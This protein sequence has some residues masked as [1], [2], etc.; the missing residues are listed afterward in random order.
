MGLKPTLKKKTFF[1]DKC[2]NCGKEGGID[3]FSPTNSPFYPSGHLPICNDC[4]KEI[5]VQN[6]FSWTAADQLCQYAGIPFVPREWERLR[7]MN[8]DNVF[9]IYANVFQSSE[10]DGL[11]WDDYNK[12]FIELRENRIIDEELPEIREKKYEELRERWGGNYDEEALNYL[13]QLYQGLLS[14]QNVNGPQQVDQAYKICKI[15]YEIDCRI[16]EG[17]DFDKLLSSYEK[18]NK[19]ADFTPKNAKNAADFDSVGELAR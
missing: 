1:F 2:S 5:L 13:E 15:S 4:I 16:R 3:L 14:S 17:T 9:P 10:Y 12:K 18:L 6:K 19:L 8:G 11:G 7:E